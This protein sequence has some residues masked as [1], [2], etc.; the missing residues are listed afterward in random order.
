MREIPHSRPSIGAA[1]IQALVGQAATG[2]VAEGVLTETL[3]KTFA[4]RLGLPYAVAA[5]SGSQALLIALRALEVGPGD[6]VILPDYACVEVLAVVQHLGARPVI[7]DV[8]ED[9]L[10]SYA[11][12]ATAMDG[13]V[14][15]IV[16]PYTMG[17]FRDPSPLRG[18]GLPIV[19]D[20]ALFID[21]LPHRVSA[22]SGDIA[23]F[24]FQG[25]KLMTSGEGGMVATRCEVLADRIRTQKRFRESEFKINLYPLSD[26]QAAMALQQMQRLPELLNRRAEIAARYFDA[27]QD[28]AGVSLPTSL[29]GRSLYF[30]FPVRLVSASHVNQA[31][32]GMGLRGVA[33]RRPIDPLLSSFVNPATDTPTAVALHAQTLSIPLHPSLDDSEVERVTLIARDALLPTRCRRSKLGSSNQTPDARTPH[34]THV[35]RENRLRTGEYRKDTDV[36]QRFARMNLALSATRDEFAP[37]TDYPTLFVFGLPRSGTTLT[38]QLI[39]QCL[40]VGYVNNLIARFWLSPLYGIALSQ[41]V[42]GAPTRT[43]FNSAF[44]VTEGPHGPHEFGYFWNHW[45]RISEIDD[46]LDF[47]CR[48]ADVDWAKLG[49]TVRSMQGMFGSGMVFKTVY[50]GSYIRA[51]S[52]TFAMPLFIYIERDPV[53]VALS[54]LKARVAYYGH[55][56]AWW[57]TFPPNYPALAGLPFDRQI[58]G[59]V[60]S[61]RSAYEETMQLVSPERIVRL[62]YLR[63]CEDPAGVVSEIRGRIKEA[64]EVEVETRLDPPGQFKFQTRP[65]ELTGNQRAVMESVRNWTWE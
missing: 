41:M 36:E 25:T 40:E 33:A 32:A 15:A 39:C 65:E 47:G 31:I 46:M 23:V 28:I 13:A 27:L 48:K 4:E 1:E 11:D 45:L 19:E 5:G 34:R 42:I 35:E 20:C 55:A 26:L 10:M 3:E 37:C 61:L 43:D 54:I 2:M 58:A 49:R 53:D 59:Q 50:A 17:I 44:G 64:Y 8:E 52:E 51:F 63:L 12:A 30:R 29:V 16:L 9:Y 18:L 24:S 60:H 57:S 38:Y 7:V 6:A 56:Q 22:V 14:K 21:P 62:S